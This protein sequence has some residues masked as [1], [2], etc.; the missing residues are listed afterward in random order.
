MGSV[1][2]D[3]RCPLCGR[4]GR[5]GY[6]IDWIGQYPVCTES[7]NSCLD[8]VVDEDVQA[9][10]IV[11]AALVG[12]FSADRAAPPDGAFPFRLIAAFLVPPGTYSGPSSS[13]RAMLRIFDGQQ[14]RKS[15]RLA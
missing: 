7:P 15:R 3:Y 8:K 12:V 9:V 11:A 1:G 2:R 6:A 14:Q 4:V 5:G 10:D 13:R